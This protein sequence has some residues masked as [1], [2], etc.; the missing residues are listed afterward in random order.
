MADDAATES[1][2]ALF[3]SRPAR[4]VQA[5]LLV[6]GALAG[7]L[8]DCDR[9]TFVVVGLARLAGKHSRGREVLAG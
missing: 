1:L 8:I 4:D 7:W 5:G 3:V 6:A 9:G 2:G